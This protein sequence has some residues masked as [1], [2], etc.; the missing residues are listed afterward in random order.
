[1]EFCKE[2]RFGGNEE[3]KIELY[4]FTTVSVEDKN[5]AVTHIKLNG[6]EIKE[7]TIGLLKKGD[8]LEITTKREYKM[9]GDCDYERFIEVDGEN[10]FT[11]V[12]GKTDLESIKVSSVAWDSKTIAID[13]E[14]NNGWVS[15]WNNLV[16]LLPWINKEE[17]SPIVFYAG[18]NKYTYSDL[19]NNKKVVLKENEK[20]KLVVNKELIKEIP[21]IITVDG[22][23]HILSERS[24]NELEFSYDEVNNIRIE[25][26]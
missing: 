15:F 26:E 24:N 10:K 23:Q 6:T 8:E 7:K 13:M 20:L 25:K 9:K 19:E 17:D 12:I 1:L 3:F 4:P 21:L 18:E 11:Y 2:S 5:K 16:N 22:T 14:S